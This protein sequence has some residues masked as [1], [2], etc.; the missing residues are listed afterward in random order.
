MT[1]RDQPPDAASP[2]S[3]NTPIPKLF[4][5]KTCPLDLPLPSTLRGPMQNSLSV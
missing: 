3:L 4:M 5:G 2:Q 1:G